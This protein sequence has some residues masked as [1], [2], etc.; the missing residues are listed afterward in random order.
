MPQ[1]LPWSEF[2]FFLKKTK[3]ATQTWTDQWYNLFY[4]YFEMSKVSYGISRKGLVKGLDTSPIDEIG[5]P[6]NYSK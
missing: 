6:I 2:F 1:N 5:R 4:K 3:P